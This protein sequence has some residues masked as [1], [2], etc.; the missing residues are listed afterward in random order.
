VSF[1]HALNSD[2]VLYWQILGLHHLE[3]VDNVLY[4]LGFFFVYLSVSH[5]V[6]VCVC[7][8]KMIAFLITNFT[9]V[10]IDQSLAVRA[11]SLDVNPGST[12]Y[13]KFSECW[14]APL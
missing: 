7:V 10:S 9:I 13:S 5:S 1:S 6:C 12:C 2:S 14:F 8:I 11:H 3:N 4:V